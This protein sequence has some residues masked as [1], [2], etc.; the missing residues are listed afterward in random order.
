MR[1]IDWD[2]AHNRIRM[3]DQRRLPGKLEYLECESVIELC[4]AIREMAIRGAPA[5][6]VAGGY[7]IALAA[8]Q[9]RALPLHEFQKSLQDA[10]ELLAGTRPTA[11]NL[12]WGIN[13]AM[14]AA[15]QAT[16]DNET[17][18][19]NLLAFANKMAAEDIRINLSMAKNGAEL[20]EDGDTIIHHCNTGALAAVD[21]GTAL[22]A[23]RYAHEHG[24]RVHVL[25]DETRPR[26]QGARLT[27][28]E[29]EQY[30]IPY[31]II[32]ITRL[33]TSCASGK[34][35]EGVLRRGPGGGQRRCG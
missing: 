20:I 12:R 21:W 7:G 10:V 11:V 34:G 3:V 19:Q 22:G 2:D 33:G 31:E 23:I 35:A 26:L 4:T 5:L 16:G 25:V 17:M 14:A 15:Q 29:C 32:T 8:W 24:K 6:G 1:T 9:Y 27:A 30:G 18:F 13:K 28:W